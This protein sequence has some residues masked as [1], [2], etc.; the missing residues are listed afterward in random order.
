MPF[1]KVAK[2]KVIPNRL[3]VELS[4]FPHNIKMKYL[5][6]RSKTSAASRSDCVVGAS[7]TILGTAAII[8]IPVTLNF[9][10]TLNSFKKLLLTNSIQM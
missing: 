8:K 1:A 4:R 2:A 7:T 10:G 5:K 6:F 3:K 9:F